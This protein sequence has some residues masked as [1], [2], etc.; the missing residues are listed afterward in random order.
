[1]SD[2]NTNQ[3]GAGPLGL[4]GGGSSLGPLPR[5]VIVPTQQGAPTQTTPPLRVT[6]PD[7]ST[8]QNIGQPVLLPLTVALFDQS[9]NKPAP[10]EV[11]QGFIL[12]CPLGA[13]LMAIA[14]TKPN[15]ISSMISETVGQ[16]ESVARSAPN[17]VIATTKRIIKVTIPSGTQITTSSLI[18]QNPGVN[19]A[20][21]KSTSPPE[22]IFAHTAGNPVSGSSW[23]AF[24]EKAY[25]L[26][27]QNPTNGFGYNS[28]DH[29]D[30]GEVMLDFVG[31]F[32]HVDVPNKQVFPKGGGQATTSKKLTDPQLDQHILGIVNTAGAKAAIA[33]TIDNPTH[34]T[35]FGNHC[36]AIVSF[37]G[38]KIQLRNALINPTQSSLQFGRNHSVTMG[39]LKANFVAVMQEN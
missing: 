29:P 39:E 25:A 12:N 18:Y 32:Q 14:A 17:K 37:S 23:V 4:A 2:L 34:A 6:E 27:K 19:N 36:Y 1:M 31:N 28:L 5:G 9:T 38:G 35:L 3:T 13:V 16:V 30:P 11:I 26:A 10:T 21:V 8:K 15:R 22:M 7:V 20:T 24:I 33:C